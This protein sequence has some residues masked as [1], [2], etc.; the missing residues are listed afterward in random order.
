MDQSSQKMNKG[1]RYHKKLKVLS[2][3]VFDL[4]ATDLY[5]SKVS[6]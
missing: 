5:L 3:K 4:D 1:L 2:P 6:H